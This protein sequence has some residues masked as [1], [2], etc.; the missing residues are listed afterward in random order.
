M[1][2]HPCGDQLEAA[3]AAGADPAAVV[4]DEY[5]VVRGGTKPIPPAG[6]T[7]S[8]SVGPTLDAAG[9]GVQ[10]GQVRVTTAG[11][12]R[13][14]GGRVEWC[15]EFSP[16]GTMNRQH[17]HV[18]EAGPSVFPEPVPNPVPRKQRVDEGK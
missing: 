10:H 8:T 3:V 15:P 2:P 14:A 9:C 16:R 6:T 11:A 17:A 12:I 13:A 4:P 1:F 18:T 7:F 5:V